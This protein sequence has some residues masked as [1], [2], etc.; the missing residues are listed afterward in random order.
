VL[1][2]TDSGGV[3]DSPGG[4]P[5]PRLFLAWKAGRDRHRQQ[6]TAAHH[7]LHCAI[8][9][10]DVVASTEPKGHSQGR[11]QAC[12]DLLLLDTAHSRPWMAGLSSVGVAPADRAEHVPSMMRRP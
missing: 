9:G 8:Q 3:Q 4:L 5:T 2:R 12:V 11:Q 10:Y 7:D 6:D 1:T